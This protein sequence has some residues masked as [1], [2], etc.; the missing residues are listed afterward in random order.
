[1]ATTDADLAKLSVQLELQT[2][3]FEAGVKQV[4]RQLKKMEDNTKKSSRGIDVLNKSISKLGKGFAG[5]AGAITVG[6][7]AQQSKEAIE[8]ADSIAKTADKVGVTTSELQELRFAAG[9]AGIETR[10]LDMALQRFARR[11]GEAAT[12][13]G[14]LLKTTQ[15]LGIEFQDS[16]GR[17]YTTSELLVQYADAMGKAETQQ[18]KLRLAFK[19]FD[20]EGAALVNL[21]GSGSEEMQA[22]REQ[23]VELGLVLSEDLTRQAEVIND[24]FE[25]FTTQIKVALTD[26]FVTATAAALEFFDVFSETGA[27]ERRLAEI[28]TEIDRLREK[29]QQGRYR[30]SARDAQ[31]LQEEIKKREEVQAQLDALREAEEARANQAVATA[32]VQ[33]TASER[34]AQSYKAQLNPCLL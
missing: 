10:T 28:D 8:Y 4:D 2:A 24:K 25:I 5:L 26:A 15:E 30:G 23:A 19:A 31:L 7:L 32:G 16:E 33:L 12:G 3:A 34:L 21:L 18:E 22:L 6:A 27:A 11:M 17:F 14:E 9:Q 20:S 29:L 1:M 13:T